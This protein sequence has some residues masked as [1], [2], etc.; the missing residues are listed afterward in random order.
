MMADITPAETDVSP[1]AQKLMTACEGAMTATSCVNTESEAHDPANATS[2][3]A[4]SQLEE[5]GYLHEITP[6]GV[7][8]SRETA[9]F[10][11]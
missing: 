1:E 7:A 8:F 5:L 9:V 4:A 10:S 3:E 2:D 6:D 11:V